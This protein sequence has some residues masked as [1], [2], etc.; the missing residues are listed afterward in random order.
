MCI[1]IAKRPSSR[2]SA[3]GGACVSTFTDELAVRVP[4]AS[5]AVTSYSYGVSGATSPSTSRVA[6]RSSSIVVPLRVTS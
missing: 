3:A 6:D 4:A 5:T 1:F 2:A